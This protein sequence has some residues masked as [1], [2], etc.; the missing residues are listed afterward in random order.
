MCARTWR[1]A[2]LQEASQARRPLRVWSHAA[3]ERARCCGSAAAYGVPCYHRRSRWTSS[4]PAS[5]TASG[6]AKLSIL[7]AIASKHCAATA[8]HKLNLERSLPGT[9]RARCDAALPTPH[10]ATFANAFTRPTDLFLIGDSVTWQVATTPTWMAKY[11]PRLNLRVTP[12]RMMSVIPRR[13]DAIDAALQEVARGGSEVKPSRR[14]LVVNV[15]MWYQPTAWCEPLYMRAT[16]AA[17]AT[18]RH[19]NE[20]HPEATTRPRGT[21]LA[22][23]T[24]SAPSDDTPAR[25][26]IRITSTTRLLTAALGRW[27]TA[28]DHVLGWPSHRSTPPSGTYGRLTHSFRQGRAATKLS[29]RPALLQRLVPRGGAQCAAAAQRRGAADCQRRRHPRGQSVE[30]L[31]RRGDLHK[32]HDCT[33]WWSPATAC[34]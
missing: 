1:R 20:T 13:S 8:A 33:H 3:A 17:S 5:P 12:F 14:A 16:S 19:R 21:P 31:R 11:N 34:G 32:G 6:S 27:Q 9:A 10:N 24:P 22:R 28:R 26:F 7:P 23:V 2:A 30:A 18:A 25:T 29:R 4:T 15:G